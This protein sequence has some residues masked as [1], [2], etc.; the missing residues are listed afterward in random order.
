MLVTQSVSSNL[1][2]EGDKVVKWKT[3][4]YNLISRRGN[5]KLLLSFFFFSLSNTYFII[6][7]CREFCVHTGKAIELLGYSAL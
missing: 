4:K 6:G 5:T 1:I 3:N 7:K 2:Y